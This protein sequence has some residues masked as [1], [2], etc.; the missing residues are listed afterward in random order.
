MSD[1]DVPILLWP[2]YAIWRLLT[3]VLELVG[4]LL[5]AIIGIA[6]MAAGTAIAITVLAAPIG[7]PIA[8]IG[9]LLVV[10]AIF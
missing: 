10:R 8:A 7:I 2:F 5:C 3:F 4:R 9:F 1:R 6:L